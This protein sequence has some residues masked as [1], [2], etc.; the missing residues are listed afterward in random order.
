[1]KNQ[2]D[3]I[4]LAKS[5]GFAVRIVKLHRILIERNKEFVLSRQLLRCGT[6]IGANVRE[7]ENGKVKRILFI[8]WGLRKRKQAKFYIG[9]N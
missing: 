8:K 9:L 3:N 4:I 5:F 6:S 7:A 1:M 2:A